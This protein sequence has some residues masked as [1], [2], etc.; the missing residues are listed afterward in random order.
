[1]NRFTVACLATLVLCGCVTVPL[2]MWIP[3]DTASRLP[4]S[5]D[6]VLYL[7]APPDRPYTVVGIITPP[8]DE[9]ETDAEAVKA[10]RIEAAKHGA[11][12][13]FIESRTETSGWQFS[14]N[15]FGASGGNSSGV[16]YRAKAIVW[17]E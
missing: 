7:E 13:I 8:A 17:K 16:V 3:L 4:R 14:A 6:K 9:Y 2:E 12:A 5:M 15:S 11:D 1:M 10:M